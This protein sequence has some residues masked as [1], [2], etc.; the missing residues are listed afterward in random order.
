MSEKCAECQIHRV[1]DR[2]MLRIVEEANADVAMRLAEYEKSLAAM[3]AQ[4]EVIGPEKPAVRIMLGADCRRPEDNWSCTCELMETG[5]CD[6][7]TEK[8]EDDKELEIEMAQYRA[9]KEE[10]EIDRLVHVARES[11]SMNPMPYVAPFPGDNSTFNRGMW[12]VNSP[13]EEYLMSARLRDPRIDREEVLRDMAEDAAARIRRDPSRLSRGRELLASMFPALRLDKASMSVKSDKSV[14]CSLADVAACIEAA[15]VDAQA[16]TEQHHGAPFDA[17]SEKGHFLN[18]SFSDGVCVY[19]E[20]QWTQVRLDG[21]V[22][23]V[24]CQLSGADWPCRCTDSGAKCDWCTGK[25][26][27]DHEHDILVRVQPEQE[28]TP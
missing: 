10:R 15:Q 5:T 7:C 28:T 21:K 25:I 4:C 20:G 24:D 14:F 6:Y 18:S 17:P 27:Y 11:R 16:D 8:I 13:P 3:E 2:C 1:C 23:G 12:T 22:P 26:V 9:A 19:Q